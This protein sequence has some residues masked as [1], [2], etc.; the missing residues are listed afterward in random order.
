MAFKRKFK[1]RSYNN[2]KKT[3][4]LVKRVLNNQSEKHVYTVAVN[5]TFGSAGTTQDLSAISQGDTVSTRDGDR[6]TIKSIIFRYGLIA[7]DNTNFCRVMLIQWLQNDNATAPT[8]SGVFNS[9]FTSQPYAAFAPF[10][11][12][13]AGY[14]FVPLYDKT[15][16]MTTQG[17]ASV[18]AMV[19]L[20]PKSFKKKAKA[21]IN[22]NPGA[23]TGVGKIYLIVISDSGVA[24]DPTITGTFQLRFLTN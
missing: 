8:I 11:K 3:V 12:A 14:T 10:N 24:I 9:N 19:K 15:F 21:M 16:A 20:T 17:P 23:T 6:L 7:A 4:R 22:F 2:N 18:K 5:G 1:K 13:A